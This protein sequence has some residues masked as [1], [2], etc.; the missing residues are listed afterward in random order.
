[1]NRLEYAKLILQKVSFS[2]KLFKKELGKAIN[3]LSREDVIELRFW[4]SQNIAYYSPNPLDD[5]VN[6]LE[7]SK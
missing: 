5:S 7:K 2:H 4:C 1:M 6:K 3:H